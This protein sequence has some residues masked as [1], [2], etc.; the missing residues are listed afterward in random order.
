MF[1]PSLP[2]PF[3]SDYHH[4]S[5]TD[6]PLGICSHI[7]QLCPATAAAANIDNDTSYLTEAR[8]LPPCRQR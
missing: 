6:S 8:T 4:R 2:F 1:L 7:D 3:T 5:L